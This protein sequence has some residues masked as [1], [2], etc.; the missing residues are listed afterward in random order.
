VSAVLRTDDP[1][2][3]ALAAH[4]G[5]LVGQAATYELRWDERYWH[6]FVRPLCNAA[7]EVVGTVGVAIDVT[8]RREMAR[9]DGA[10][11]VV[12]R[13]THDLNNALAPLVGFSDLLAA[14][15]VVSG[16]VKAAAYLKLIRDSAQEL[17]A[18]VRQLHQIVRLEE[19]TWTLGPDQP[20]LDLE[21]SIAASRR[22]EAP[23]EDGVAGG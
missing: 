21:R 17:A 7:G 14:R 12:R 10:L 20:L 15:P 19:D 16:D 5:A 8:E 4:R 18:K 11:L 13:V 3:P 9:L 22:G 6:A 2:F 1:A 23:P